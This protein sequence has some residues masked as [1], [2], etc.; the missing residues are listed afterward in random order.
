MG[1][2]A[3]VEGGAKEKTQTVKGGGKGE[4]YRAPWWLADEASL[5]HVKQVTYMNELWHV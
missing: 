3:E 1:E 4:M 2:G 5:L